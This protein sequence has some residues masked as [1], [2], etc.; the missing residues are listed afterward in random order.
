MI[1]NIK[2][3]NILGSISIEAIVKNIEPLVVNF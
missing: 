3:K 1:I 2:I